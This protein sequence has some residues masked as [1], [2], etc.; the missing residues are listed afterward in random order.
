MV[1]ICVSYF[2][3]GGPILLRNM[4]L[5]THHQ[6]EEFRKGRKEAPQVLPLSRILLP[7]IHLG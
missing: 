6:V 4:Q 2:M 5:I 1:T 3:T 7:G